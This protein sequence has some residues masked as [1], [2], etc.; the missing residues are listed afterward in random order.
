MASL[1]VG[2]HLQAEA[3]LHL[4]EFLI[5]SQPVGHGQG[6]GRLLLLQASEHI[7]KRTEAFEIG[8]RGALLGRTQGTNSSGHKRR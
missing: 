4:Q 7:L 5:V 6:E 8:R 2:C 1:P 3:G